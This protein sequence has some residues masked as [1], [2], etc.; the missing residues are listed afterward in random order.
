MT[1]KT[2]NHDYIYVDLPFID[3]SK[4]GICRDSAASGTKAT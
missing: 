1:R 3:D 4:K 2:H